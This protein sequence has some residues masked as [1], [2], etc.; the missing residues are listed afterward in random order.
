ML[1]KEDEAARA[2]AMAVRN[3]AAWYRW[4]HD[5]VKVEGPDAGA[6]VNYLY[7]NDI[8]KAAVGRSKYTTMLEDRK[9]VV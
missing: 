9:S 7:V 2:E 8:S 5:L 6:F 4:T 1:F 3:E